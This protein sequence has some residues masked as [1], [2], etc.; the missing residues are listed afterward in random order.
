MDNDQ[1]TQQQS[2]LPLMAKNDWIKFGALELQAKTMKTWQLIAITAMGGLVIMMIIYAWLYMEQRIRFEQATNQIRMLTNDK[3]AIKVR[4]DTV[5]D[6]LKRYGQVMRIA[7][8]EK[9][10]LKVEKEILETRLSI[11]EELYI[12]QMKSIQQETDSKKYDIQTDEPTENDI[13]P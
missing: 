5:N 11:L 6:G 4:L 2:H 8:T 9:D 10:Q 12:A 1:K 7:T 3:Q 13:E